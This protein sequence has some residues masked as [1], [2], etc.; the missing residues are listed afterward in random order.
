MAFSASSLLGG[1][2]NPLGLRSLINDQPHSIVGSINPRAY[3][4]PGPACRTPHV[5]VLSVEAVRRPASPPIAQLYA[6]RRI[7]RGKPR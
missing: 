7:P 1:V 2:D 4:G 5:P 6:E 3:G